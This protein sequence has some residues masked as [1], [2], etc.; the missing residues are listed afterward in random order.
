M[1][2]FDCKNSRPCSGLI[3]ANET[4]QVPQ[5]D[6]HSMTIL[7][8]YIEYK[9]LYT[10]SGIIS[11]G[12]LT[13]SIAI[14][15]FVRIS[16]KPIRRPSLCRH[17]V[18]CSALLWQDNQGQGR[19]ASG[20]AGSSRRHHGTPHWVLPDQWSGDCLLCSQDHP[21]CTLFRIQEEIEGITI[22]W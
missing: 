17:K 19:Q 16:T 1:E 9:Q 4:K 7:N 14:I 21:R 12:N 3:M 8:S 6:K 15:L 13:Q 11:F 22:A 10:M 20:H 18:W 2:T 5:Y